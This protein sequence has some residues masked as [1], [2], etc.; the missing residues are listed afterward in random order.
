MRIWSIA[1]ID[2]SKHSPLRG[3]SSRFRSL[4]CCHP[5]TMF[6]VVRTKICY[7]QNR[8]NHNFQ[9]IVFSVS[10]I[11]TFSHIAWRFLLPVSKRSPAGVKWQHHSI[12]DSHS[13]FKMI[14]SQSF[15]ASVLWPTKARKME[16][17]KPQNCKQSNSSAQPHLSSRYF[18]LSW[19]H[20][21]LP[22]M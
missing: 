5:P 19:V 10:S 4:L 14:P 15:R 8:T 18:F 2:S 21:S 6:P 9:K 20:L 13:W 3:S 1:S 7:K 16:N 17:C 11:A 12:R 22:N